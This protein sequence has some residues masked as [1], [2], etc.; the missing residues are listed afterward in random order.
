M[1]AII[2]GGGIGGMAAALSLQAAGI[3]AHVFEAAP[4]IAALGLGIHLQPNA[5]RELTELGLADELERQAVRIEEL[6]FYS[7]RGQRIWSEPRGQKAGYRWPQ[8][9]INRG[10][11]QIILLTAAKAR[12]GTDRIHTGHRLVGFDQDDQ[13]VTA[14]FIDST[15][16]AP[17][18][19]VRGD[20]L[21]G[22]DGIHSVVRK[23]FYPDQ[24]LRFG[25]Q[26][27][28]RSAVPAASFLSGRTMIIAGHR[29]QKL[30]CYPM[31]ALPDG[32][33]MMNWITELGESGNGPPREEWNQKVDKARF[34][35]AFESWRFDWLDV[36]ALIAA[37]AEV[38]EFPKVDR[39]PVPRWT[40]GRVTLVGDAAHPMHP[41]GSQAGSQAVVDARVLAWHLATCRLDP[42]E[43]LRRYEAERLPPMRDI[44]LENRTLGPEVVMELVEERAPQG[45]KDI[46]DVLS[47][48]ELQERADAFK[49]LAGF[50]IQGLNDRK[51][52][53]THGS[54]PEFLQAA[55]TPPRF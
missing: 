5:V 30:V 54:Y 42:Q 44:A 9:A 1:E 16:G 34:A 51:S 17:L 13:G 46:H 50:A 35:D 36:P 41:V 18:P 45:F 10:T 6:A 55:Y 12:L 20:I 40:F 15:T 22:A 49:K 29:N 37:G 39:D 52:Y 32:R 2:V 19:P 38:F 14:H 11:L 24:P 26:L 27:M 53:D 48:Q 31:L 33:M 25:G 3:R 21:V 8:Y 47:A 23:H 7:K 28:W 4:Q 43:G